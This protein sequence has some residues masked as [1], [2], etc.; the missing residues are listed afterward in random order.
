MSATD[1]LAT[2]G[3]VDS[4]DFAIYLNKKARELG[5]NVNVT[6]IQKWLYICYGLYFAAYNEQLLKERPKAWDYGPAFPRVHKKQKRNNDSLDN[7]QINIPLEEL[8][9]YNALILATLESFGD[10][11]ASE[12]V[13]WTHEKEKAWHKTFNLLDAK[14]APMD[15]NDIILDFRGLLSNG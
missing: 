9:K 14:Y 6:K 10:W 13:A 15:N 2:F 4:V 11:T 1:E 8:E 7:L 3:K 12:L 5:K